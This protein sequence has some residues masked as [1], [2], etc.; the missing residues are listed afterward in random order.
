[1][2]KKINKGTLYAVGIGPGD[3]E[4]LTLKAVR[5]IRDNDLILVPK[6]KEDGESLALSIVRQAVDLGGKEVRE[7]HFPMKKG[8]QRD[9]LLPEARKLLSDMDAGRDAVFITLGDPVLYSTFFHL[10]D[11]VSSLDEG[12]SVE[13]VPGVSSVM[14]AGA[15]AGQA[16]AL[17][18]DR[19]AILP[20]TYGQGLERALKEFDTVVLMKTHRVM[21]EVKG[22]LREMGLMERAWYVARAGL[23]EEVVK[24]LSELREDELDYFSIVIVRT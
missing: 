21:D 4:L 17:A 12:V 24:P 18:S 15:A 20:A 9:I 23:P 1:M 5:L 14:A 2:D 8:S 10:M 6:G 22:L 11:A 16:L 7:I 19:V 13:I 3:P